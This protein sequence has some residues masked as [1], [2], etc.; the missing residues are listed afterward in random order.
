LVLKSTKIVGND[1]SKST[2]L[3]IMKA[4]CF[5]NLIRRRQGNDQIDSMV[6]EEYKKEEK[7]IENE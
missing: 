6:M 3:S 4:K 5:A 7:E 2:E 1:Q